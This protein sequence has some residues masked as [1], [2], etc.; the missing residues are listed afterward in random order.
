MNFTPQTYLH[1][2][3]GID[4]LDSSRYDE[5]ADRFTTA[6]NMG[7][8]LPESV[9]RSRCEDFTVVRYNDIIRRTSHLMPNA[10]L[11]G[12]DLRSLW[13]NANKKRCHAFLRAGRPGEALKSYRCM[14][15]MSNEATKASCLDWCTGKPFGM[16][17]D[18][19][20]YLCLTPWRSF[21]ARV[22]H[23][24]CCQRSCRPCCERRCCPCC[25]RVR[26]SYR[27]LLG[28]D[29][30]GFCNLYHLCQSQ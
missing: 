3:V 28:S 15:D 27:D 30:P 16:P 25:R 17:T 13:Q 2:Q 21:Q 22:Q 18:Y 14:M 24:L 6:I 5:A 23:A 26:Q 8:F 20:A 12:W 4:H 7:T 9:I 19:N 11:F 29:R 1:V 10:Q